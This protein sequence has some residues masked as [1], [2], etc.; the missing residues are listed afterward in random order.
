MSSGLTVNRHNAGSIAFYERMGFAVAGALVQEIGEGFVMDDYR[1]VK[2]IAPSAE[3][4]PS[5]T[6]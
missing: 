6:A 1:M 5:A 4:G 3:N 2:A